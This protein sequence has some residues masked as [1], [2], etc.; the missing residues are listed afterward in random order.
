M[1]NENNNELNHESRESHEGQSGYG[2]KRPYNRQKNYKY[3]PQH[4]N[5]Y[6]KKQE[7]R[8]HLRIQ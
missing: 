4:K 1:S 5:F 8:W 6:N 2:Q 7:S 3:K